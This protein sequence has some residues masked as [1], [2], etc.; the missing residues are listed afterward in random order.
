MRYDMVCLPAKDRGQAGGL[1]SILCASYYYL[2]YAYQ[3][4]PDVGRGSMT[5]WYAIVFVIIAWDSKV[6]CLYN[7]MVI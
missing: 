6:I 3:A 4:M 2:F 5:I 1:M 7:Y